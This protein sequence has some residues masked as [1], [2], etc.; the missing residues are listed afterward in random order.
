[1]VETE[2]KFY[3]KDFASYRK[4]IDEIGAKK[5]SPIFE[6]NIVFDNEKGSLFEKRCLLRLRKSDR[7]TLTFKKPVEKS[8]YKVMEEHEIEVSDF[9]ETQKIL[10][11]LGYKKVFRYQKRRE[12]YQLV[13]VLILLDETPIGNFIEIEGEKEGIERILPMLKLDIKEGTSKNYMELYSDYCKKKGIKSK[14]MVF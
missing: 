12:I 4:I 10:N 6:D 3:V 9:K 14:D 1:M 11:M 13:N 5:E 8:R 2:I 7:T